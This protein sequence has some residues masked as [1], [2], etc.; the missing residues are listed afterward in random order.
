MC[1]LL[2]RDVNESEP[3]GLWTFQT[4]RA[5]GPGF[6]D[7][8]GVSPYSTCALGVRACTPSEVPELGSRVM[9]T[10]HDAA[11]RYPSIPV[12]ADDEQP[13]KNNNILQLLILVI[14]YPRTS[15]RPLT[16]TW[17]IQSISGHETLRSHSMVLN[18]ELLP[19]SKALFAIGSSLLLTSAAYEYVRPTDERCRTFF[20]DAPIVSHTCSSRVAQPMRR[21]VLP[22]N[23]PSGP[24]HVAGMDIGD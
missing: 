12:D 20:R 24:Q 2:L 3:A 5:R 16:Y 8:L 7:Q 10:W 22:R 11:G 9:L 4:V 1:A 19:L 15:N 18:T 17:P 23:T 13:T 14:Q 6:L 21:Q